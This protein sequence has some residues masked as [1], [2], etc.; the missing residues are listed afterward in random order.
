MPFGSGSSVLRGRAWLGSHCLGLGAEGFRRPNPASPRRR[1]RWELVSGSGE[2]QPSSRAQGASG[3]PAPLCPKACGVLGGKTAC[4]AF[5]SKGAVDLVCA[6][7]GAFPVPLQTAASRSWFGAVR[8][9]EPRYCAAQLGSGGIAG[10]WAQNAFARPILLP[11]EGE[12]IG[13]GFQAPENP[14]K[15]AGPREPEAAQP[16]CARQRAA[17]WVRKLLAL[18]S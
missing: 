2:P 11:Q 8:E 12:H 14:N 15:S 5:L 3:S 10:A 18:L 7:R 6:A 1:T 4:V 17:G 13:S 16:R 9:T